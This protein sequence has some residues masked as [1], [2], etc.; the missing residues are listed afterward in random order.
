MV[1]VHDKG[2]WVAD[3]DILAALNS[4]KLIPLAQQQHCESKPAG[5][6]PDFNVIAIDSWEELLEPPDGPGVVRAHGNWQARLAASV[7]SVSL[8]Y[9]TVL[10]QGHGCWSSG[11]A[12][13]KRI[14]SLKDPRRISMRVVESVGVAEDSIPV[15]D[16]KVVFVL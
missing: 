1:S 12:I 6:K 10:F 3:L 8:G 7:V 14:Q 9:Q 11:Q 13:F 16:D 15:S 4:P 2:R 5:H